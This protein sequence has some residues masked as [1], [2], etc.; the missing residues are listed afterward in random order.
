MDAVRYAAAAALA[1]SHLLR[2][3]PRSQPVHAVTGAERN[4]V[5]IVCDITGR[6]VYVGSTIGRPARVR[7]SEHLADYH[8][9]RCWAQV[10]VVPLRASVIPAEVRRIEGRI[11]RYLRPTH[12]GALPST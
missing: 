3:R 8:R 5:Y 9:T 2:T 7:L 12:N 6:V 10:W 1:G 4:A 11:G